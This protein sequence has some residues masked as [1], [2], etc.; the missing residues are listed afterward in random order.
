VRNA[1]AQEITALSQDDPRI[2]LLSGDIGNR[3]FDPFKAAFP[4]R[5]LNCGVAEAN[6]TGMAAGLAMSGLRPVTYTIAPFNTTRCLEQIKL[7][8]CYHNLAVVIVGVGAGLAYAGLGSTHHSFED[9]AILRILPNMAVICP[10]DAVE[11]RLALKAALKRQGPTYIR[12]GKKNEPVVHENEPAFAI[13]RGIVLR[14]GDD[15]C[16]LSTGNTLPL[17]LEATNLLESGGVTVRVVSMHTVKPLDTDLLKEVFTTFRVVATIEEHS[18]I[19]GFASAVTEWLGGRHTGAELLR[20]GI[21]DQFLH[22]SGN[23][24]HAR[25]LIGL[26]PE[27]IARGINAALAGG[28][29]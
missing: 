23:Q 17:A 26:T 7:D 2:V 27:N 13:G 4:D 20:F 19:G 22:R 21:G 3:L 15:A 10:G 12:L 28:A 8:I 6:M 9:I 5:F 24:N 29:S 14:E 16:L 18:L 11:V 25:A 1:F